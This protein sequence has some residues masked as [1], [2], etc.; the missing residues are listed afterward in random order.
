MMPI[1][2]LM[3]EH[4]LIERMIHSM[5]KEVARM[6]AERQ[7]D[8]L[9]IETA[10]DF[11]K[12][13]ADQCHHGKEEDILFREL[14]KKGMSE[15]LKC[16]MNELVEEHRLGRKTTM[17]LLE[18]KEK[19]QHGDR[20]AFL[21]MIV[22]MEYLADFYPKHIEKEDR[23]FFMP[24]MRYFSQEEKDAMLKEE[25]EFDRQFV[26]NRYEEVVRRAENR[27]E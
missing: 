3:I 19:Y 6:K 17:E 26:H 15:D 7:A 9:F 12:T 13:Y 21:T 10:V 23:R 2:P 18:A 27:F 24:V 11:I 1:G 25:Y 4:R 14:Q 20:E 8:P 5:K 16:T 22:R